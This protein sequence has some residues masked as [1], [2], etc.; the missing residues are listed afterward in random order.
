MAGPP[1]AR[2]APARGCFWAGKAGD[3][4]GIAALLWGW[5]GS[6]G[7]QAECKFKNKRRGDK[8]VRA[9]AVLEAG[10]ARGAV[11]AALTASS[12]LGVSDGCVSSRVTCQA[13]APSARSAASV[14]CLP[15]QV[16]LLFH[17]AEQTRGAF[18]VRALRLIES[19][20]GSVGW[21]PQTEPARGRG[22]SRL[23]KGVLCV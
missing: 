12:V 10:L 22:S 20:V 19:S 21:D 2:G 6:G 15:R 8:F 18:E 16:R 9:L 14:T 7:G 3:G 23:F 1:R 17:V 4:E 13:L 11:P 5:G